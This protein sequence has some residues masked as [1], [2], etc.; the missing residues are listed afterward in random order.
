MYNIFTISVI[1]SNVF[2]IANNVFEHSNLLQLRKLNEGLHRQI[3]IV[4]IPFTPPLAVH[5][6]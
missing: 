2:Q 5:L 6:L 4:R 1:I 3:F